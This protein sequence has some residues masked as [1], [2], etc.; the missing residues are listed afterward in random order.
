MK[1]KVPTE[2]E[3][4]LTLEESENSEINRNETS[5]DVP[6]KNIIFPSKLYR[7]LSVQSQQGPHQSLF[8]AILE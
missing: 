6:P 5:E 2:K 8:P 7:V 4:L 3:V 1:K